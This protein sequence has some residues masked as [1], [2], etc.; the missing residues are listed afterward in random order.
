MVKR[1]ERAFAI[2]ASMVGAMVVCA[3]GD[4]VDLSDKVLK[5]VLASIAAPDS[6]LGD[7]AD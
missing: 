3:R 4:D 1:W 5:S 7:T 2:Y 6:P